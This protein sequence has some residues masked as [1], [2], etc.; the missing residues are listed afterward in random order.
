MSVPSIID[1]GNSTSLEVGHGHE[2]MT[3]RFIE[4]IE[5][6]VYLRVLLGE[7]RFQDYGGDAWEWG[8]CG[9]G[10]AADFFLL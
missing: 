9:R 6:E 1:D 8:V 2:E 4:C 7:N 3:R 10:T 5:S